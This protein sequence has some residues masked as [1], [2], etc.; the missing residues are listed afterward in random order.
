MAIKKRLICKENMAHW[1]L[2]TDIGCLLCQD[3][4]D[5]LN[6]IFHDCIFV[7]GVI[8]KCKEWKWRGSSWEDDI[9]KASNLLHIKKGR[10][11]WRA[12]YANMWYER[13]RRNAGEGKR[14]VQELV[15]VI[16]FEVDIKIKSDVA[17][18]AVSNN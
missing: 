6:H 1:G 2:A 9:A 3:G 8:S 12:I 7:K 10:L 14:I 5:E 11:I 13:C 18:L 16:N 4:V 17:V 15:D